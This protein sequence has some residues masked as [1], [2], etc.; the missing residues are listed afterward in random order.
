MFNY[1]LMSNNSDNHDLTYND[2]IKTAIKNRYTYIRYFYSQYWAI[3][4][5]GGTFFKP[6]FFEFN[7]ENWAYA[8]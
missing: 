1:K 8:Y 6:L 7:H 2:L 3:T 5:Y 4:E